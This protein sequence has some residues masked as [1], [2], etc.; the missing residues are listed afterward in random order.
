M[1]AHKCPNVLAGIFAVCLLCLASVANAATCTVNTTQLNFGIYW[2]SAPLTATANITTTCD[3]TTPV[4]VQMGA[5]LTGSITNRVMRAGGAAGAATGAINYNLY[6]DTSYANVWG[7]GTAGTFTMTGTN[8]IVYGMM[9]A[10]QVVVAGTYNDTV[11]VTIS[12]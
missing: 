8:L 3:I 12:W 2:G 1:F 5:G 11:V 9:P 7:D 10:N 4:T 6:T